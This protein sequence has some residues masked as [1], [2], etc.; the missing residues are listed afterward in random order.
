MAVCFSLTSVSEILSF[1]AIS[2]ISFGVQAIKLHLEHFLQ[3]LFLVQ[4]ILLVLILILLIFLL[5]TLLLLLLVLVL[6]ILLLIL[7][8]LLLVLVLIIL[9]L[10]LLLLLLVLVLKFLLNSNLSNNLL[11]INLAILSLLLSFF[12][13]IWGPYIFSKTT[14]IFFPFIPADPKKLKTNFSKRRLTSTRNC[15][16]I[17]SCIIVNV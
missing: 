9:L 6:I 11:F 17:V 16:M 5:L 15:L 4:T 14:T 7:L 12:L 13:M 10:I 1:M 2:Q 8:L 3:K